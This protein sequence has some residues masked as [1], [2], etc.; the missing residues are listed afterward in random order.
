M[1]E[2]IP[3]FIHIEQ[4]ALDPFK[5]YF[6]L[7]TGRIHAITNEN[8]DTDEY[9]YTEVSYE[10]VAPLVNGE[11]H[12]DTCIVDFNPKLKLYELRRNSI[13]QDVYTVSDLIYKCQSYQDADIQIIQDVKNTCWKFL[14]S[15]S[16]RQSLAANNVSLKS[17]LSFS[18]TEEN[19]PNVL[20]RSLTFPFSQL[21]NEF[22]VIK[23]FKEQYEF[24]GLPI[25]VY[26]IK[27]FDS[28]SY[29]VIN[30]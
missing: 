18:I 2:Q 16:L 21:V 19:N 22:Y 8:L 13:E 24:D 26:T 20:Y 9:S 25:S 10:D 27:R 23:D 17:Q 7:D 30:E 29:E 1:Q 14:I 28:Y 3:E 4:P 6:D 12:F 5:V 11:E 15:E